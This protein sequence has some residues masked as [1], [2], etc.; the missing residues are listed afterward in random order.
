MLTN[1]LFVL[2]AAGVAAALLDWRRGLYFLILVAAVQD[3]IRKL[4]PGAPG[5]LVLATAPI[6]M[7]MIVGALGTEPRL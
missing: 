1:L 5:Y 2:I 3:P 4:T 6:W 7:A